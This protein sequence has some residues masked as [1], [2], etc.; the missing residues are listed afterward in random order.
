MRILTISFALLFLFGGV[1]AQNRR[2]SRA[3]WPDTLDLAKLEV[4]YE[5]SRPEAADHSVIEKSE[6][7]LIIGDKVSAY[8]RY[9]YYRSDSVFIKMKM[10]EGPQDFVWKTTFD[11]NRPSLKTAKVYKYYHKNEMEVVQAVSYSPFSFEEPLGKISWKMLDGE[12]NILGYNCKKAEGT[13]R[14]RIW[15]V[16]YT[17]ELDVADGPWKLN[18]LPGLILEAVDR[19]GQLAFQ[20]FG[21][22]KSDG[23]IVY[24]DKFSK[25]A[26]TTYPRFQKQLKAYHS[27]PVAYYQSL[28]NSSKGGTF[29]KQPKKDHVYLELEDE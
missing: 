24:K 13:F 26:K 28:P 3:V 11:Y 10:V 29:A 16:W 7:I 25:P 8:M 15:D 6:D 20:A 5:F 17:E 14:G 19:T 12:K 27:N 9:G 1:T 4:L 18:G 22:R 21:V 23:G 2:L